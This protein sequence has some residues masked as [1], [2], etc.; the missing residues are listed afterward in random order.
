MGAFL[1][2]NF[3]LFEYTVLLFVIIAFGLEL[4]Y[5]TGIF[6]R[7]AF[8]SLKEKA[9]PPPPSPVSI[10]ICARNEYEAL[11]QHLKLILEQDYPQFEVIVVNDCSEDESEILLAS[12]QG[13][14]SHL[15]FRTL[16]KD[17]VF[18]HGKKM[19]LGVGIKAAQYDLLLFIDADCR[20]AGPQWLR[21]M[22]AHFT[23]KTDIVLGYTRH[24]NNPLWLR[25]DKFMQ[26]FHYLGKAL[27][28]K[29]YMGVGSNL[30][31]RKKI[32]FDNKGFDG[33]ITEKVYED[34]IF[35]NKV[36]TGSNTGVALSADTTTIST[37]PISSQRWH[38]E[39][40]RELRSFALCKKQHRYPELTEVFI[41]L[42]FFAALTLA[43]IQHFFHY[44]LLFSLIGIF[45]VRLGLQVVVFER[46]QKRLGEKGLTPMLLLWD[47][48]F[49]F[50]YIE[51]LISTFYPPKKSSNR[52]VWY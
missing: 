52:G 23:D 29:P 5:Y 35:I 14:Y 38:R 28:H 32:F 3:S 24:E 1:G 7:L 12:L 43:I 45:V 20:P 18:T 36:A 31:Y 17:D 19:S 51:L 16:I 9:L 2:I 37:L 13:V 8:K 40:L 50:I 6:G 15:S 27:G 47:L 10:V 22:Q 49:P 25:A 30:A 41:R 46:S 42:V 21:S 26:A 34:R 44:T 11:Q 39:R 33:R 48:V 4:Y